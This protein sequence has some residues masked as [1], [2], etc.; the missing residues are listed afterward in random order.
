MTTVTLTGDECAL[1]MSGYSL[2]SLT[3]SC[4]M[5]PPRTVTREQI[6][7]A[8][9][10]VIAEHGYAG[11]T[12]KAIARAARCS[13]GSLYNHFPDKKALFVECAFAQNSGL[14]DTLR[15]LPDRVGH[16]TLEANLTE[17]LEAMLVFQQRLVPLLLTN[18][19]SGDHVAAA[20]GHAEAAREH[21]RAAREH[22]T[23]CAA[24][25]SPIPTH[26]TPTS[27]RARR[28]RRDARAHAG[29]AARGSPP[30]HRRVLGG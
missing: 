8:A 30:A 7:A 13:E 1:M 18:W 6:L 28:A 10:R 4:P 15:T 27:T 9:E 22:A 5:V 3:G 12:T 19:A 11:A 2:N 16:G 17:V 20:R 24:T 25:R 14:L 23:R 29:R 26:T 21:A